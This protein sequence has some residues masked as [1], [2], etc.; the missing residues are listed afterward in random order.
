MDS[1]DVYSLKKLVNKI[2]SYEPSL[3]NVIKA[4]IFYK[5]KD[6]NEIKIGVML[7]CD[8]KLEALQLYGHISYS[9]SI[10]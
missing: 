7:W 3:Y 5:F 8:N 2:Y 10:P 6:N 9:R 1:Q 4:Q